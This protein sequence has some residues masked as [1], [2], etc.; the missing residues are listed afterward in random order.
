MLAYWDTHGGL[1]RFGYLLTDLVTEVIE[2]R[3]YHR[4]H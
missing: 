3:V 4:P 1:E 2:G